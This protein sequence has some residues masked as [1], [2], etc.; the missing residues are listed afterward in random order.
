MTMLLF[1]LL[2][3]RAGLLHQ[4]SNPLLEYFYK[5]GMEIKIREVVANDYTEV[6]FYGMMYLA[7]AMLI[8]KTFELLW[9]T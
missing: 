8:L 3:L 6:V 5:G 4:L 7:F 2:K 9:K 1:Y